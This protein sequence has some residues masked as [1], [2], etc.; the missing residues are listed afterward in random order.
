MYP[1][2]DPLATPDLSKHLWNLVEQIPRGRVTTYGTLAESLGDK[3]ASRWVGTELLNH[4]HE[5]QCHCHRVVR[6]DGT[7]GAFVTRSTNDKQQ[8]LRAEGVHVGKKRVD[9]TKYLFDCFD[10]DRPLHVLREQQLEIA[11]R[12]DLVGIEPPVERVAGVDV[13]YN[14]NGY[15]SFVLFDMANDKTLWSTTLAAHV[16]FPYIS[17]YLAF[18]ELP[19]MRLAVER[20]SHLGKEADLIL[21]DGSG[22]LHPRRAGIASLLGVV[23]DTPTIGISK[24]QL[25]GKFDKKMLARELCSP[26]WL[27]GE[28]L[29]FAM[30][31]TATTSKPLFISPGHKTNVTL[32]RNIVERCLQ[33]HRVPEPIFHADKISRS[34]ARQCVAVEDV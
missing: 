34:M 17:S 7:L 5:K 29:G 19:L 24:K 31:P 13:S 15:A 3:V 6:A 23:C 14:K 32:A 8:L 16:S 30:L 10:T 9:L 20:A 25:V 33:G 21:V 12:V 2:R 27:N 1:I 18:R 28:V 22:I 11:S 4:R 26:V